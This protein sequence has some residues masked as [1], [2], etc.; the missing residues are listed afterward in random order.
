MVTKNGE[1]APVLLARL[2]EYT[3]GNSEYGHDIHC[4]YIET[5]EPD[6]C[7]CG[8]KELR[9]SIR[10]YLEAPDTVALLEVQNAT[11]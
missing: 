1:S 7:T 6:S 3:Y 10:R 11:I 4:A 2:E 8:Y 9:E 5:L